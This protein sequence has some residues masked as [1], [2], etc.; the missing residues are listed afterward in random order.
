VKGFQDR[1]KFRFLDGPVVEQGMEGQEGCRLVPEI[2]GPK[3]RLFFDQAANP[4][5]ALF[6]GVHG[7]PG[8]GG[9]KPRCHRGNVLERLADFFEVKDRFPDLMLNRDAFDIL[10]PLGHAHGN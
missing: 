10:N 6:D 3:P 1:L 2:L 9:K 5:G 8:E 7:F 4:Q